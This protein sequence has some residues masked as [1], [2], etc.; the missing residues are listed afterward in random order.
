[1]K[2][3]TQDELVIRFLEEELNG[4]WILGY[5]LIGRETQRGFLGSAIERNCRRLAEKGYLEKRRN[6]K[7]VEFRIKID[8]K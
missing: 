2:R 3:L 4:E 1:M 5:K 6:G 7:Y 8:L